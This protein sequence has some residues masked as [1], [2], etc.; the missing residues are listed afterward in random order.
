MKFERITKISRGQDGAIWGQYLF[1]FQL[2]GTCH[3][4]DLEHLKP[5]AP[6][7]YQPALSIFDLDRIELLAPHCNSVFFGSEFFDPE[8]EFPLLYS[9]VY[10]S[11]AKQP[12]QHKGMC[13]VYRVQRDDNRFYTTLVQVIRISFT[14]KM[15]LWCSQDHKDVRPYGNFVVDRDKHCLYAFTMI[16]DVQAT[17]YFAFDLPKVVD[18]IIDE[19]LGVQVVTLTPA[20][21][22]EQ[23]DCPY[24]N[25]IQGACC[26]KGTIYSLEGLAEYP[27]QHALAVVSIDEKRQQSK[28]FFAEY[29]LT[30]E[31]EL[32][33]F[34]NDT[35][36]IA[37]NFGN[38]FVASI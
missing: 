5:V 14:E 21:I 32:V 4:Y 2:D 15:G 22:L 33:D 18:G 12:D 1:R 7:G 17:R 27:Q 26:H 31:P 28:V 23:F 37:D 25:Y 38:L 13:C 10:N 9:N 3:V 29:G 20:D 6:G 16:D 8:D 30:I 34:M 11:Y 35:C 24:Q 19:Q 36:Y